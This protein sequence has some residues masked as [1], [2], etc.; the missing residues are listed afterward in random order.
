MTFRIDRGEMKRKNTKLQATEL[1]SVAGQAFD[2]KLVAIIHIRDG[3]IVVEHS[4]DAFM[5]PVTFAGLFA[6]QE[7]HPAFNGGAVLWAT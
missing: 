4:R 6:N 1:R 3:A 7:P 5:R 2:R